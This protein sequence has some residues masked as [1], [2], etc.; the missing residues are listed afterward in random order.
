MSKQNLNDYVNH[1]RNYIFDENILFFYKMTSF[2]SVSLFLSLTYA[3]FIICTIVFSLFNL[4]LLI[5]ITKDSKLP[6]F[7]R[8]ILAIWLFLD[9]LIV[10]IVKLL[11][12]MFSN[13]IIEEFKFSILTQKIKTKIAEYVIFTKS[14]VSRLSFMSELFNSKFYF[15]W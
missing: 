12:L 3:L 6:L 1:Y 2:I 9:S 11:F 7:K 15:K 10:Q 13:D 4:S 5:K 8:I 14:K